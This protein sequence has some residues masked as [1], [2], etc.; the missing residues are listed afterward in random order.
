MW[1]QFKSLKYIREQKGQFAVVMALLMTIVL[2]SV[3]VAVDSA[4]ATRYKS[5]IQAVTDAAALAAAASG[6]KDLAVLKK[7]AKNSAAQNVTLDR[8]LSLNLSLSAD[9]VLVEATYK[10]ETSVM[11]ILGMKFLSVTTESEAPMASESPLNIALVLDRTGSMSGQNMAD[12]KEATESLIDIFEAQEPGNVRASVVPFAQYV[13]VGLHNRT[14]PW[15]DVA[16]DT[17]ETKEYCYNRRDLEQPELCTEHTGTGYNDGVPYTYTYKTCP[18]EAYG[19]Y[20][21]YCYMATY[22]DTWRGCAGSR[23]DPYN[24]NPDYDLYPIPGVMDYSC[25][26]EVLELTTDMVD[27]ENRIQSLTASGQTYIPTGLLWGW[28]TLDSSDPFD[29]MTNDEPDRRRVLVLMTDGQNT[30]YKSNEK[31]YSISPTSSTYE[32]KIGET[33]ALMMEICSGIKADD[34]EI[35]SI[36]YNFDLADAG[37]KDLV[38]DCATSPSHFFDANNVSELTA[39]FERIGNS[40][41]EVRLSK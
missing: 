29:D 17:S 3:G 9:R 33:N 23:D 8:P 37:A 38:R 40:M 12:L 25:G 16:D 10:Y 34:I 13:N 4:G 1:E 27:V 11:G 32:T 41:E 2:M 7:I 39:A 5:Q 14:K 28:R 30:V 26:E 20:Y 21:E 24:K 36:A 31:H 18:A 19:E 35:Y 6:E 22:S 15:M